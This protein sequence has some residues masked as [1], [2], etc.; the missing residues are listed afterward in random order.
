MEQNSKKIFRINLNFPL[1]FQKTS[2][3]LS[4][5]RLSTLIDLN[6]LN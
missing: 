5:L 4:F 6:F 3:T 1:S 2:A